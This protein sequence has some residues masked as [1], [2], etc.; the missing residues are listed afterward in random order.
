MVIDFHAHIYPEKIAARAVAN[1]CEF[2]KIS[3]QNDGTVQGLLESGRKGGIDRF[4]V[5]SAAGVPSQVESIH[6][7]IASV[8]AEHPE[9]IGFGTMHRDFENPAA[10]IERLIGLGLKGIKLHPDMQK[11]NIDDDRM[12]DIYAVLEGRL[13][14]IFHTGD[15]RYPFSHPARLARVLDNFPG[16]CVVAAHFG[17]WSLF[18][19]ALEYFRG[20]RCYL[21][22]SS[23]IPFLG[24]KRSAELIRIYGA[25]RILFGSD[26]PM[27]D[28]AFCLQDFLTLDL[29]NAERELILHKNALAILNAAAGGKNS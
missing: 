26:Y 9:F 3:M 5:F 1:I 6:N 27:W 10:E 13:P 8:C 28:P 16:L 7:Y 21:D 12:M 19:L 2:Y 25:E 4:V 11:F 23:A 17:G 14:V 22:V 29:S 20:R 15:Y 18:D 24:K